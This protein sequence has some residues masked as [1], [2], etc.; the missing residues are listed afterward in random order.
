MVEDLHERVRNEIYNEALRRINDYP[1]III[2]TELG[3][4]NI[5]NY[6]NHIQNSGFFGGEIEISIAVYLYN[7][8]IATIKEIRDEKDNIICYTYIRY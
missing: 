7:I 2:D 8:N 3:P 6:V 4:I 5:R 1:D